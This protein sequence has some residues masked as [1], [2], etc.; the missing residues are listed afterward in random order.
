MSVRLPRGRLLAKLLVAM[1]VPAIFALA[2]FGAAAHEVARRVLEQELGRRLATAATSVAMLV[3]PEQLSA[4]AA[5]DESSNTYANLRHRV[6]QARERL[7]V[8]RVLLVARDLTVRAD[9]ENALPLGAQAHELGA[10][11]PE[12]ERASEGLATAS[13]LFVGRDGLPYKRGYARVG[14][15]GFAVVEASAQYLDALAAFRRWLV[16]GG[17]VSLGMIAVLA[18]WLSRRMTGPLERLATAAERIGQGD[19]SGPVVAETRDE[20][21]YLAGRLDEMRAALRARD[22]R[23]QMMLAGIAH[24]VRN[25]LGGLELYAGLLRE[26]LAGEPERLGE[27]A[28]IEREIGYLKNVV[29]DFLD[30]ARRPLLV[31]EVF[32]ALALLDEIAEISRPAT[33]G[34][35]LSVACEPGLEAYADRTQLRRA[36]LNLA[37]NAILAAGTSGRVILAAR[38][39]LSSSPRIEWEVRDSGPGVHAEIRDKIFTPFFTTRERGTGLGLAFVA[40]IARDHGS[41]VSVDRGPEGG[42]RFRFTTAASAEPG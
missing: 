27:I 2:L 31:M 20:I 42:A 17:I 9:S 8:R 24:E 26:G 1:L 18:A 12:I 23:M 28:R 36:L 34:P 40:E 32:P 30:F 7:A 10:D 37:K 16:V 29:T 19:L 21:G 5:G 3:L 33:G 13:P 11:A 22:E 35:G 41:S 38:H 25:P 39:S 6:E 4:I 14:E 15:T